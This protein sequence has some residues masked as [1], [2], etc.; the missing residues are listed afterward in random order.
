MV[1][2]SNDIMA[3]VDAHGR[4]SYASPA[5]ERILGLDIEPLIGRDVFE[6]IHPDDRYRALESFQTVMSNAP[7][8]ERVEFRLRHADG[9][10]R[11]VEA[12]ATNLLEDPAVQGIVISARD[13]TERRRASTPGNPWPTSH[14]MASSSSSCSACSIPSATASRPRARARSTRGRDRGAVGAVADARH[15]RAVHLVQPA[16]PARLLRRRPR[17][18]PAHPPRRVA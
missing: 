12:L 17:R 5:T 9:G 2:D 16:A 3:I 10:W 1:R 7:G 8:S 4:L 6:L 11:I 14:P 13:L 15:E 18:L